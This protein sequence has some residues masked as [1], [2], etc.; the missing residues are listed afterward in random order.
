MMSSFPVSAAEQTDVA[1]QGTAETVS[2]IGGAEMVG[3]ETETLYVAE[4]TKG[5]QEFAEAL[6][7]SA[8][9]HNVKV[10]NYSDANERGLIYENMG[11]GVIALIDDNTVFIATAAHCLKYVH[12]VVEFSDGS[13]HEAAVGYMNTDKDVG[14]LTVPKSALAPATLEVIS[15]ASGGDAQAQGKEKGDVLVAFN[16]SENAKGKVF[17]GMLDEYRVLY[18][19]NPKQE[20]MQFYSGVRYGSSGGGVYTAE[21]VWVGCISGGDTFGKC[22]A[23][24]FSDILEEWNRWLGLEAAKQANDAA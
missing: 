13:R 7:P 8:Y 11:S 14:F 16:C 9:A 20:V 15:P 22:W 21:G 23:V 24:P 12:T 10:S 6:A 18:P 2:P 3:P 19:N 4:I 1:V 17:A 5:W